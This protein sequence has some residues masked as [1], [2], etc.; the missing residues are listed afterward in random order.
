[1]LITI[2][3]YMSTPLDPEAKM[4]GETCYMR[5]RD[6]EVEIN[7]LSIWPLNRVRKAGCTSVIY[8]Q[9]RMNLSY[10]TRIKK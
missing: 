7:Y 5:L 2:Q 4:S 3:D 10:V 9:N 8:K 1:M 6:K